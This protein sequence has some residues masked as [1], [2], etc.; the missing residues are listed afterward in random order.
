MTPSGD[1]ILLFFVVALSSIRRRLLAFVAVEIVPRTG[2]PRGVD[3]PAL[4]RHP[5]RI[6]RA[7]QRLRPRAWAGR[8]QVTYEGV[9]AKAAR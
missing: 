4:T 8:R 6:E 7:V 5:R 3:L 1:P 9:L 2:E